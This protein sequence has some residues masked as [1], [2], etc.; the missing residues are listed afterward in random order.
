MAE[1]V[2][3]KVVI[4][5]FD[6][7]DRPPE[8]EAE[9]SSWGDLSEGQRE[10]A[11]YL[12]REGLSDLVAR[13]DDWLPRTLVAESGNRLDVTLSFDL[14]DIDNT[15]AVLATSADRER[16]MAIEQVLALGRELDD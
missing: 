11:L 12:V 8:V 15:V 14:V 9:T 13:V 16:R 1:R 6:G 4:D 7:T 10:A 3:L 5:S 2:E